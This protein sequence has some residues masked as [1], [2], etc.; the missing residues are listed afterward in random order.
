MSRLG[1]VGVLRPFTLREFRLLW[2]GLAVSLLGDGLFFVA[3][4]WQAYELSDSPSSVAL[5]GLAWTAPMVAL[6]LVGGVIADRFDRRRVMIVSDAVRGLAVAAMGVLAVAGELELWHL[7]AL[8]AVYGAGDALF[9]PAFGAIVPDIVPPDLLVQANS[10]DQFVRPF[11]LQLAGPALSGVLVAAFGAGAVFLANAGSFA[12]SMTALLAMRPAPALRRHASGG[13]AHEIRQGLRFV[14]SHTWLWG[15][16]AAAGLFLLV[17]LGPFEVL[18]PYVIKTELG[19]SARDLG[20]VFASAGLGSILAAL[21]MAER[22]LPRRVITFMYAAFV[23]SSSGGIVYGLAEEIW[24]MML[25]ALAA[26]AGAGA[27][28]IVWMT[29]LQRH[30]PG[31]LLGRVTSLDWFVSTSLVPVSFALTGPVAAAL[32]ARE[33]LVAAGVLGAGIVSAFLFLPGMR[34]LE[35]RPAATSSA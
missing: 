31:E 14:R 27:G 26:G 28:T 29:L 17:W 12:V 32:G 24:P 35:R 20:L 13:V 19:G 18:L 4:A 15:T 7:F 11:A 25:M 21:V 34:D 5:I 33:T 6:L 10:V 2:T 9:P 1:R 23:L 22:R 16:L 8:A 30:V 3:L